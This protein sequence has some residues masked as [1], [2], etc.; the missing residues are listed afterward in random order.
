MAKE[1]K[2]KKNTKTAKV[3]DEPKAETLKA[4]SPEAIPGKTESAKTENSKPEPK[5]L[6][7]TKPEASK[8]EPDDLAPAPKLGEKKKKSKKPLAVILILILLCGGV[9]A[10]FLLTG[11]YK[12]GKFDFSKLFGSKQDNC[13]LTNCIDEPEESAET[14]PAEK[15]YSRLTGL[16][17]SDAKINESP[18]YCVQIPNDTYG[19]RPQVGLKNAAIVFE[20]IAEGGITR[21][22]AIFQN[23][24]DSVIGPIRSLR[25]YY[26]DWETPF[27]CTL[28]HAGGEEEAKNL[29]ASGAYRDLSESTVYMYRDS[30]GYSAP[31]NLFTSTALLTKFNSDKNYTTSSPKVFARLTPLEAENEAKLVQENANNSTSNNSTSNSS[32]SSSSTSSASANSASASDTST[33]SA[34]PLV[35]TIQIN[36]GNAARSNFNTVYTYNAKTNSY[37]RAFATGADH[38]VYNCKAGLDQPS[39]KQEC[40][41]AVQLS[42]NVVVA[43]MVDEYSK[44]NGREN[45]QTIGTGDAYIFQNGTVIKARW[46]KNSK[47]DQITFTNADGEEVKLT[48]GQLWIAAVPNAYGSV[49]Y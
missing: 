7:S 12:D 47:S 10:W 17:I 36:F 35:E 18:V 21:L 39:P 16:E 42:P 23:L 19:A 49:K 2:S 1:S 33:S 46:T 9:V 4:K 37:D 15:I 13:S 43:M 22:G 44:S 38:I 41:E 27:D 24:E 11:A 8:T 32:T 14:K 30:R 28:V 25:M 31:N 6:E 29:A 48:P 20:A 3:S 34:Q 45:I 5:T 26:L 40:G